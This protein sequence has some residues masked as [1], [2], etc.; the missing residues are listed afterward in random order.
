MREAGAG[1]CYLRKEAAATATPNFTLGD[2][3]K[4]DAIGSTERREGSTPRATVARG[5][6]DS[7]RSTPFLPRLSR[8][9]LYSNLCAIRS[10]WSA[11]RRPSLLSHSLWDD[12]TPLL[13]P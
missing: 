9:G 12:G 7:S 2:P 5:E 1:A 4:C 11:A 10:P 6:G 3:A 13:G 8:L